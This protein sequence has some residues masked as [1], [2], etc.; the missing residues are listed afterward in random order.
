MFEDIV[1]WL[2]EFYP[3]KTEDEIQEDAEM[4]YQAWQDGVVGG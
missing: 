2:R 4:I 3:D 1:T